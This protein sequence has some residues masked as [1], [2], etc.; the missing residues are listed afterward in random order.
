M[1]V[2]FPVLACHIRGQL[3]LVPFLLPGSFLSLW[4]VYFFRN[5]KRTT[6][7]GG[8]LVISPA[9]GRCCQPERLIY[10]MICRYLMVNGAGFRFL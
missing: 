5:P 2:H 1:A 7:I 3:F 6:P 8:S 4:C 10:R 9:D